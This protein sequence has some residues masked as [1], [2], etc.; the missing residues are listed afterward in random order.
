M[1]LPIYT[2]NLNH[3]ILPGCVTIGLY[4]GV[5]PCLTAATSAEK[6]FIHSPHKS[7]SGTSGGRLSLSESSKEVILLN[8]NQTITAICA[9]RLDPNSNR[10]CLVVGSPTTLLAYDVTNNMDF[11]FK[12]IPDG[13]RVITIGKL[14]QLQQPLAI[15][16][17]NCSLQGFDY[18]GN[19]P[20][21]TVTGDNVC[22]LALIDF[23]LDGENELIVGSE[24]YDIRV[25]KDDNIIG[26]L[27][28]TEAVT[29]LTP[30]KGNNFGYGLSNGTVGVYEKLH[31]WWRIKSKNKAVSVFN[32]D[33]D[34]DGMDELVTGWSNGK[35]D[36]RN[37]RTGEVVFKDNM[38]QS[39]AGIVSGD[40]RLTG[41]KDLICC[42]VEGEVR[43]YHPP[44]AHENAIVTDMAQDT[45][46]ELLSRKQ[47]LLMELSNYKGND[48]FAENIG[49]PSTHDVG[50]I[51]AKTKL[52]TSLVINLGDEHISP[53]VEVVLCTNNDTII[54]AA[55][56]FGEGIFK[57]ESH[58]IHP[59]EPE[60]GNK[61]VVALYPPHNVPVDL[62]IKTLVGYRES[63]HYH[64]FELTRQMPRF[65][66][67]ALMTSP[68]ERP[69]GFST[70]FVNERVQRI[71]LWVNQNF[72]VESDV[73]FA[74]DMD[75]S[76]QSLRTKE[77][78]TICMTSNGQITIYSN[79]MALNYEVC[80]AITFIR[81]SNLSSKEVRA[82]FPDVQ[83][84]LVSMLRKLSDLQEVRVQLSAGMA[85]AASNIRN[86]VVRAE[87]A[88]LIGDIYAMKKW[89]SQLAS[90]NSDLLRE[91][92]IRSKNHE[93]VME[94]LKDINQCIQ[95][96]SKL[97]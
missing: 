77:M 70:F 83:E 18:Q 34:G 2:L 16:G 72:L 62:H 20:F 29:A 43:G 57:G 89:Y 42:S 28:E 88:R 47:H 41:S 66:M 7:I 86:L 37:S 59:K 94:T 79:D 9:G 90:M 45:V 25:F 44:N 55:L 80:V 91:Y 69:K 53:H 84:R 19:D 26:E 31:R 54:R 65:A 23:D 13:V 73:A 5:H 21:W 40:Y 63:R 50:I 76:F 14:G 30:L 68:I 92:K 17:G 24:D 36:G 15:I 82:D 39:I 49:D 61:V 75:I 27:T 6:I 71:A 96:A 8:V 1:T 60:I 74:G 93:D 95:K 11:F 48:K 32:Y 56:V 38:V 58:V 85:E 67:F 64:I 87:D 33:I 22:S 97:R 12:E 4:D 3:K 46:R 81:T 10:D 51:P 35:I 52:Q 78:I